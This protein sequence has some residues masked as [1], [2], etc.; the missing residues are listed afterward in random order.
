MMNKI[1]ADNTVRDTKFVCILWN[2]S[3]NDVDRG[4]IGRITRSVGKAIPGA[5]GDEID[6]S[7]NS[8]PIY[9]RYIEDLERV[10]DSFRGISWVVNNIAK[11]NK[12]VHLIGHSMGCQ[13]V[14][15]CLSFMCHDKST[16]E[17]TY[18]GDPRTSAIS[19][20]IV[21]SIHNVF[22]IAPDVSTSI[23]KLF[24]VSDIRTLTNLRKFTIYSNNEDIAIY[25][26]KFIRVHD[27]RLGSTSDA[28]QNLSDILAQLGTQDSMRLCVS[29]IDVFNLG[30]TTALHALG[31]FIFVIPRALRSHDYPMS[32]NYYTNDNICRDIGRVIFRNGQGRDNIDERQIIDNVYYAGRIA[33]A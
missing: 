1:C 14:L 7:G 4:I 31:D 11:S 13:A 9:N 30:D 8:G 33:F 2:S 10:A 23:F 5:V 28:E 27:H 21:G 19:N 25:S 3:A 16:L 18:Y 20:T 22:L 15:N 32:H 24:I 6:K 12:K 29:N 26:S 17:S